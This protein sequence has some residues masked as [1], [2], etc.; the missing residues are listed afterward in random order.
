M[1]VFTASPRGRAVHFMWMLLLS[2]VGLLPTVLTNLPFLPSIFTMILLLPMALWAFKGGNFRYLLRRLQRRYVT[3][4]AALSAFLLL[5]T[6]AHAQ[7]SGVVFRDYNGDGIRGTVAP[8]TEPG[9][10]GVTV[11]ATDAAGGNLPVTY[12][13]GGTSTDKTGEYSVAS[14]SP[15]TARLEF[16]M[17]DSYTYASSG[18]TGG[19]TVVFPESGTQNLG[20][21]YPADYCEG[22]AGVI[23]PCFAF[24]DLSIFGTTETAVSNLFTTRV[25]PSGSPSYDKL[26]G[27][28][29]KTGSVYGTAY[30]RQSKKAYF[31]AYYKRYSGFGPGNG[32]AAGS[33]GA[34]YESDG[35]G[36]VTVLIDLPATETGLN[37]HPNTIDFQ[38]DPSWWEVGKISWGDIDISDDGMTLFAMNLFNRNLYEIDIATKTVKKKTPI[39]GISGGLP[40]TGPTSDNET[41]LRPFGLK[42]YKG[43]VYVGV[44]CTAESKYSQPGGVPLGKDNAH[45]GF[46]FTYTP[47][48]NFNT[49]PVLNFQ[50]SGDAST[51]TYLDGVFFFGSGYTAWYPESTWLANGFG[52]GDFSVGWT[53]AVISDIDFINDQM[54]IGIRN[55]TK[56]LQTTADGT[57][58][59]DGITPFG[60]GGGAGGTRGRLLKACANGTGGFTIENNGSCGGEAGF[61]SK[62]FYRQFVL[63]ADGDH[64]GS[65]GVFP[66]K[67]TI[68][69]NNLPGGNGAATAFVQEGTKNYDHTS[70]INLVFKYDFSANPNPLFGKANGLGDVEMMCSPAPL[71]IGNRVWMDTDKDGVQDADEMGL[72]SI[73]VKLFK[74]GVQVGETTTAGNGTYYFNSTNVNLNG[75]TGLLPEM[76]YVVRIDA[77]DF[78]VSKTVSP[79]TDFGG[80]GQ[81]DVRDNDA[82]LVS[83]NAEIA[84]T[85]GTAGQNN[86]TLDFAFSDACTVI[87]LSVSSTN[88]TC[89]A[90]ANG[91][92]EVSVASGGTAPFSYDWS[93]DGSD[94]T[95]DDLV[96]LTGVA[97]GSYTVTVTDAAGC[98]STATVAVAEPTMILK[99]TVPQSQ[100]SCAMP[101]GF[102][103]LT[104]SGGTP[105]NPAYTFDWSND[106]VEDPD[107]DTEDLSGITAGT[108]T[109]TVTDGNGCA[110]TA[111]ATV[112]AMLDGVTASVVKITGSDCVGML[113]LGVTGGGGAYTFD[114]SNDG[115]DATDDDNS[116]L[117]GI[118]A[119]TYTVTVTSSVNGCSTTATGIYLGCDLGDLPDTGSGN[120]TDNYSTLKADNGPRH[121][122]VMGLKMGTTTL[123]VTPN[124]DG[125]NTPNADGDDTDGNDDEDGVVL[126]QLIAGETA[127]VPVTYC[128]PVGADAKLVA[129][130]DWNDNGVFETTEMVSATLTAG[131]TGT[132]NLAVNVPID[133]VI[134]DE[135]GIRFRLSTDPTFVAG[136]P[137]TGAATSGEVE[138]YIATVVGYDYGDLPDG[139]SGVSNYPTLDA[140]NG[141]SHLIDADLRLGAA[142]DIDADGTPTAD[143]GL[144]PGGDDEAAQDDEDGV[145]F[146]TVMA[147]MPPMFTAG[148]PSDITVNV[149]N[150]TDIPANVFV[151]IDWNKNGNLADPGEAL[152]VQVVPTGAA[153]QNIV[154]PVTAP[155]AAVLNMP[156]G[157]RV[158]LST[159]AGL[160][161]TGEAENGE[162][163][164]YMV[165]VIGFD[166]GDLP[167]AD[168]TGGTSY[169][170]NGVSNGTGPSHQIVANPTTGAPSLLI[171]AAIDS[172][173]GG[174]PSPGIGDDNG[175]TD[176]EDGIILPSFVTGKPE[177]IVVPVVNT[178]GSE[179]KLTMFV[180][181]N[182]DG[183]FDDANE[184]YS[185]TVASGATSVTLDDVTPPLTTVLNAPIAI[186]YR[187]ST[188]T[189]AAMSPVGPAPDGEVQDY[190]ES[191]VAGYDYGDL[192]DTGAGTATAAFG[193][194]A[195]HNTLATDD[196]AAHKITT[197]PTT[198]A[199]T[200]KIGAAVDDE[201]TG[202][203][204]ATAGRLGG[205]DDAVETPDDEDGLTYGSIPNFI[206]TQTTTL[207]IPVMNMTGQEA[208]L[209]AWIDF[210]KDGDFT[211]A[212]E[213]VSASV[214]NGATTATLSIPVPAPP[215]AAVGEYV[216]L[217]LRLANA[218][219]PMSSTGVAQSGEVE[220]YEV[221][222]I[223]FDYGDLPETYNTAG[224]DTPPIHIVSETLKLGASVD[225]EIDGAPEAMAGAMTG[226][227]DGTAGLVTFGTSTPAGDDENGVMF[228]SPMIP[229]TTA[230]IMVDA[231]NMTTAPAVLQA[232]IDFNGNGTFQAGEQ[233]TT[234]SFA[235]TGA[236]VPVGGLTGA[237]LTFNVP[238]DAIFAPGGAAF[239]R[240]R[241]SPA[242]GL[243][244]DS[245][246][247][248]TPF[249]EIE[250]YKVQLGKVGNLVFEDYDFDGT[251][252]AGEPGINGATVTLTWL[253]EDG[254]VGGTGANADVV[255]PA[256]TTGSGTFQQGEYYF[257]GLTDG[258]GATDNQY[259]I[260][261]QT[262][263]DMTPTQANVG[264]NVTD[265]DGVVTGSD[266]S[267]V[268]ETFAFTFPTPTAEA[269]N[270]D[271]GAA[272]VGNFTDNILDETHDFGFV[273]IDFGDLP[274]TYVTDDTPDNSGAQHVMQ[275]GKFLGS[276]IDA[277]RNATID[278]R[279]GLNSSGDDNTPST[280]IQGDA[281][282]DDENGVTFPTP[283]IPGYEAC[284][285][286]TY[287]A[288]DVA[289]LTRTGNTYLSVWIDYNGNNAFD[290]GEQ[291]V[292]DLALTAGSAVKRK[293][294]FI[295]PNTATFAEGAARVRARLHCQAGLGSAGI[296]TGGEVE[297]YYVPVA[298]AGNYVW[299]DND[300]EGD[301]N[302]TD[303]PPP[304]AT[305][306][307]TGINSAT[308][309]LIWHG[310]DGALGGGDDR[311]YLKATAVGTQG[312]VE[313]EGGAAPGIYYFCGL[314]EGAFTIVPLKYATPANTGG[315]TVL[316]AANG[317]QYNISN[318]ASITSDGQ[319][320]IR[321]LFEIARKILTV[322]NNASATDVQDS[323]KAPVC[324]VSIPNLTPVNATVGTLAENGVGDV[325]GVYNYPDRLTNLTVDAGYV[326]EPNIE[327]T[328]QI[329]GV[330]KGRE[331]GK[332]QLTIDACATNSGGFENGYQMAVPL[333]DV[334]ISIDL[335]TQ[336]GAAF[337]G[338]IGAPT[339]VSDIT[340]LKDDCGKATDAQTV[341]G[342]NAGFNGASNQNLL[343][344]T[345]GLLYPGQK[346]R[347]RYVVEID[348]K[349]VPEPASLN[350]LLQSV[351]TGNA[352]NYAGQPILN[353]LL[354]GSPQF[355]ARDLSNEGVESFDGTYTDPDVPTPVG[356]CWKRSNIL[357]ANDIITISVG[358]DCKVLAKEDDFLERIAN[359]CTDDNFCLPMAGY[360][361]IKVFDA[362]KRPLPNPF[363]ASA[364]LGQ[365]LNYEVTHVVSC[366]KIKGQFKVIDLLAPKLDCK[367]ITISCAVSD[368]R[369]EV[370]RDALCIT[371]A[372][373]TVSSSCG[374]NS[375]APRLTW[376]DVWVDGDCT[377]PGV[378]TRTW[379]AVDASGNRAQCVQK[380][381]FERTA[382]VAFKMP[383]DVTISCSADNV[384]TS[385]ENTGRPFVEIGNCTVKRPVYLDGKNVCGIAA[386]Y[387]DDVIDVCDG[388]KKVLRKWILID[389]CAPTDRRIREHLQLIKIIDDQGPA[390]KETPKDISVSTEQTTCCAVVDLPD[391]VI[392]DN[393][394]R[395]NNATVTIVG[396]DRHGDTIGVYRNAART[397]L[398]DFPGNNK[399][400]L[401]TLLKVG[402]TICL[403]L[404]HHT[405][406]YKVEDDC[407]N[408][409]YASFQI[410]VFDEEVPTARGVEFTTVSLGYGLDDFTEIPGGPDAWTTQADNYD[411][412][413]EK[414][415]FAGIA[416]A[417]ASLFDKGSTD[418]C[419]DVRLTARRMAPYSAFINGLNNGPH[420]RQKGPADPCDGAAQDVDYYKYSTACKDASLVIDRGDIACNGSEL[421]PDGLQT[422]YEVAISENDSIKFYCG[423]VGSTQTVIL[424]VYQV[425]K[426][427]GLCFTDKDG[428]KVQDADEPLIWN[429]VMIQVEVQDKLKPKCVAPK[430]V[431][432]TCENFDRSLWPYGVPEVS[433][434]CCLDA[435]KTFK[436]GTQVIKGITAS[437][438]L[439]RFDTACEKGTIVRTFTAWDCRGLTNTCRQ[440]IRV[441]YVQ[442]YFV[443]F[444][445]DVIVTFCDSTG[446]YGAPT[447]FGEDC[448]LLGASVQEDVFTVVPDA[449]FKIERTWK[450]INWCT[451]NPNL[452]CIYVPNPEPNATTNH[453]DNL[454]G[455][456]VSQ[457]DRTPGW[458]ATSRALRPGGA[459]LDYG[460]IW[461]GSIGASFDGVAIN[462]VPNNRANCYIYKQIIKI[463]DTQ[464]P[465]VNCP[466]GPVD[467]CDLTANDPALWNAD[468]WWDSSISSH[469]L[470]ESAAPVCITAT[471]ACSGANLSVDYQ[472][473]L[474]LNG[475]GEM[476]TVVG[477]ANLPPANTVMFDNAKFTNYIGGTA[478]AFDF[479]DVS[480]GNK[481][482]FAIQRTTSGKNM[483]ACVKWNTNN[484]PNTF[485]DAQLPYG[486]HK[487][488]WI[489]RD[490]CG[491][492]SNC[493][494]LIVVKDCKKPTV[495]C[496]NGLAANLM[497]TATPMVTVWAVD[498][499]KYGEDNCT[500]ANQL[501][502]SIR[503]KGTGTGFPTNADGTPVTG[504]TW[505]CK[506]QGTQFVELWA[507]DKGGNVDFCETYILIQDNSG[508][509]GTGTGASVAGVLVTETVSGVEE[510]RIELDGVRPNGQ[511][512]LEMFRNSDDKG[513]YVFSNALP[514]ASSYI[515][516]PTKDDNPLNGVTTFDLAL[517]TKH[518][519]GQ[520]PLNTPYKMIAA[521]ANK[522]GS[523]TTF[524]IVELRKLILGIYDELPGNTSWRFVDKV[525]VFTNP[526]NPFSAAFP[527]VKSVADIRNSQMNNDFVGVKVGDVNG[528]AVANSRQGAEERTAGTLLFDIEDRAVKAGEIVTVNFKTAEKALGYQFTLKHAGLEVMDIAGQ[529]A[530]NFG[531]FADRQIVTTSW[532]GNHE[533][534]EF[535]V[536]FRAKQD[537]QLSKLLSPSSEV[538]KAEG[539]TPL[540]ASPWR[541]GEGSAFGVSD[542]AFRFYQN[543]ASMIS[544]VGFELYQNVPNP[545][546]GKTF[547]G[548]N[549]PATSEATLTIF[550]ETGRIIHT[551]S[552]VF[553]KG[554][555]QIAID[556]AQVGQGS[557]LFYQLQTATDKAAKKMVQTTK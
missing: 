324:T 133:A 135:I 131:S 140:S 545:F 488:K 309:V 223:G 183:D 177:D 267:M 114:W 105:G 440:T 282:A 478:R 512:P 161:A 205:G 199:V 465:R 384:S 424:R 499:L 483:T 542:I 455:V 475:D 188:N 2:L 286:V 390:F 224:T 355:V 203:P 325:P 214:A 280:R 273:S 366:N 536:T 46:V 232:W 497:N 243:A 463:I 317:T 32:N 291:A 204:S 55:L 120:G 539:Y 412:N 59:P 174:Q 479:R 215:A 486:I 289:G 443:R 388:T 290:T 266:I 531:V 428:D 318:P 255:Y 182:R 40:F 474:D 456:T 241:L 504:L 146:P 49:T 516:T 233:L 262:P 501:V 10:A 449:C 63:H 369:P 26:W 100:T 525:H 196:G 410:H 495:V 185:T 527:E 385:P 358:A 387:K 12:T 98:T 312:E 415:E 556:R 305:L 253:G 242:G 115:S 329:M 207:T 83:S 171:G 167:D 13:G 237:K 96:A 31:A 169:P 546:V 394:S 119:G 112:T 505:D 69:T 554:Y 48:G 283:L 376:A 186:R 252:D 270:G 66:A 190:F 200:L 107:N 361:D 126:P 39:P 54:V 294:T 142:N 250:D 228:V 493:E 195:N 295:V 353:H 78:P 438:D 517:M 147:G 67:Q 247:G 79:V 382:L 441:D 274:D 423:E 435:T 143:A 454:L 401:D 281:S 37:P 269:G 150:N 442:D 28:Q 496:A 219:E 547:I 549:L 419:G 541:G 532:N 524:D 27:T 60:A 38:K 109:V 41:D 472:L 3:E 110:M 189:M 187:L 68:I 491:N 466:A 86:H 519:L 160:A 6:V 468:Y 257:C 393:C 132:E 471:D 451:Y 75:A 72:G 33:T 145:A 231:M 220:D 506:E 61:D 24:G 429:E 334:Q 404:G 371:G 47:S 202:Q 44:V 251:Q 137:S 326:Q 391:F 521:D 88:L 356:D 359:D 343:N 350:F 300:L 523:I 368:Y 458:Q 288:T 225:A 159:E 254:V 336:L 396:K 85:T 71:E 163:E 557:A 414:C 322:A 82:T 276:N 489:V 271:S 151:F 165:K 405:V 543:G 511:P 136:M 522:S 175:Q 93:N 370:L 77:A 213:M 279:A 413:T 301:Q 292:T 310:P 431:T 477:S 227:D 362:Q 8:D 352:V 411:E 372:F 349:A 510:A 53:R 551:H 128:I 533:Q 125:Y 35:A 18:S 52:W 240:F 328:Q 56:D 42:V 21:N 99:M 149:L 315:A 260:T 116:T 296:A 209:V 395:I 481:Y 162:V 367:D 420:Q 314:Q 193:S 303:T 181:W 65:I 397:S 331:C 245:Q 263:S 153:A 434:N 239:V 1:K 306:A 191:L 268:M 357:V 392:E 166:F 277:E 238:A 437:M 73:K 201:V 179:A 236:A 515:V 380:I 36:N 399:W 360:Y 249:G 398:T 158:R 118:A 457:R 375:V 436:N 333:K 354:P 117:S 470:C 514:V 344:G 34:I 526:L 259:K 467:V 206:V 91:G 548:F 184:M 197:D 157:M 248:A 211:D 537:G 94:A 108:Y 381:S 509:C 84:V 340:N 164:D 417:P 446:I 148:V 210:N 287:T 272:G 134:T 550:D 87:T 418:N 234:G 293:V 320:V 130:F 14:A 104:V 74:G 80:A 22:D 51:Y 408:H 327:L 198:G 461:D 58:Y 403:P 11:T 81:P 173:A 339:I 121:E 230:T 529:K 492:E 127:T 299:F 406:Y 432:V 485:I 552:G 176:D 129:F 212:G 156:L 297:D 528:N 345:S 484:A 508:S 16:V 29:A 64:M 265:S 341:P 264:A 445:A 487:I 9:V 103:D 194:P 482:R 425:D 62:N 256:V 348:P 311:T 538:T 407:G 447:F 17:P 43:K 452:P 400:D 374:T 330:E 235:T 168:V 319:T 347:V 170:T 89:N 313:D 321:E 386:E 307:E 337:N 469:D 553:A 389:W 363:D 464:R 222:I 450:V 4:G 365:T 192:N 422:E 218:E 534:T 25:P 298:K 20:V 217:R 15:G 97:A 503:K 70:N 453:P 476:E 473:F 316:T 138:D 520:E 498:F 226:G 144:T 459:A 518:I 444:P 76:A 155:L 101:D 335:A 530:D 278:P 154:V 338:I 323:D 439:S 19:T 5:A 216:G 332:F 502:Y 351:A 152:P 346:V 535:S 95:D 285:E 208:K 229:G 304:G 7:V 500:P 139:I 106:G 433:D 180:D 113:E 430:D 124:T 111:S 244:P 308:M 383:A 221:Q 30:S 409:T 373:P 480:A 377:K 426:K 275:P 462:A 172:D 421:A 92:A 460:K 261:V 258:P 540:P 123:S 122:I 402:N 555:N 544:G 342:V 50:L 45:Q 416:W 178:T 246:T 141:P 448:E 507:K 364:Y 379:T 427:T 302:T 284:I 23:V 90:A 102:I 57:T 490:G 494:Y 378:A 513:N